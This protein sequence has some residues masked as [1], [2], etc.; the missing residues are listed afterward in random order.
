MSGRSAGMVLLGIIAIA[1]IGL[2][3]YMFLK[4]E[5]LSPISFAKDSGLILVGLWDNL[6]ENTDYAPYD[7]GDDFLLQFNERSF[8][9]SNYISLSNGNTRFVLKQVGLYKITLNVLFQ[10]IVASSIYFVYLRK[11]GNL[12][13]SMARIVIWGNPSPTNYYAKSSIYVYSNGTD[14]F[15]INCK[16]FDGFLFSV[17]GSN[18]YNQL[19]IEYVL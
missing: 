3:G 16:S 14:Y 15:E 6:D 7:S 5:F 11:N 2:S 12:E 4:Y 13:R 18:L 10:A 19:S 8:N 9:D 1:G 17:M